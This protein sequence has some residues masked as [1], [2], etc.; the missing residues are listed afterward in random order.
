MCHGQFFSMY[1]LIM[2]MHVKKIINIDRFIDAYIDVMCYNMIQMRKVPSLL[3]KPL[4][5][6]S[7][8]SSQNTDIKIGVYVFLRWLHSL[9]GLKEG[10]II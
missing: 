3:A 4:W 8:T 9:I 2:K 6:F 10:Y 1:M 7:F 5:P